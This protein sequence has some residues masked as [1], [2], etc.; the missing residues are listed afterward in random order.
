MATN[1]SANDNIIRSVKIKDPIAKTIDKSP[2]W[3]SVAT[4]GGAVYTPVR[5]Q[6]DLPVKSA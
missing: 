6:D 2:I 1:H 4:S 3:P 5:S